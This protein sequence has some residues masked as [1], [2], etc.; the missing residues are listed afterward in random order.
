MRFISLFACYLIVACSSPD[1]RP[2]AERDVTPVSETE[3]TA[4]PEKRP[5]ITITSVTASNPVVIEGLARTF[6]NNVVVRVRDAK[7]GLIHETFTTSR[8]EMGQHNPYRAEVF[9]TR[10]PGGKVTAEALEYSARD[11]AERS[12]VARTIP[13]GVEPIMAV[14][15]LPEKNPT[16]CSRVH[17]IQRSMPKSVSMARLLVEALL[18]EPAL[19]FPKGAAVNGIAIR[20][21]VL[22]V[23][24]NERLQNVGGSCAVQAIRAAV[25]ETLLALPAV[26]RVVITA[27]GSERLALQP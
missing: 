23:D 7:G 27:A 10:D 24:F 6:E 5:E 16:D 1:V 12:L 21:G 9:V 13:Y 22:T 20:G 8:G 19:P 4:E 17:P 25:E 15:H 26:D 11:G 18:R 2:P 14:L 3:T